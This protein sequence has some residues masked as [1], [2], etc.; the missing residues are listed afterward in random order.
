MYHWVFASLLSNI[1]IMGVEYL[2]HAGGYGSWAQ[3]LLRTGPLIIVAQWGLYHAFSHS[4]HWLTAWA[5]FTIGN[6]VMRAASVAFFAGNQV[7]S[8]G[9]VLIGIAVMIGGSLLLKGGLR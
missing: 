9:H 5:V 1:C 2:N 7:G 8:W 6:A 3:T 4:K